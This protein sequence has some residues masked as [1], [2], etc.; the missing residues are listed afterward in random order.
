MLSGG[1]LYFY[2]KKEDLY[3]SEYYYIKGCIIERELD[4]KENTLNMMNSY[5]EQCEIEL[6]SR[7][8]MVEWEKE[9][10]LKVFDMQEKLQTL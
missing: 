4:G 5:G 6:T 1:Y 9:I 2:Q 3:P 7:K 10:A 8:Q